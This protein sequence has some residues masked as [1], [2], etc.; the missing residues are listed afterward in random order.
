MYMKRQLVLKNIKKQVLEFKKVAL[1]K[2]GK[3][4]IKANKK[5]RGSSL[6]YIILFLVFFSGFIANN[7]YK[8]AIGPMDTNGSDINI[9]IPAGS[10]TDKIANILY[11]NELI[12]NKIIFKFHVLS[13][14]ANG[15]LKAGKFDL[16][17]NMALDDVINSLTVSG[18]AT[19]TVR[20]TIPEGYELN[21]IAEKLANENIVNKDRFLELTKDKANFQEKYEFLKLLEDGQSLEGFLFPSTYEIYND[22][23]EEV[24]IEKM[25]SQFEKIYKSKIEAKMSEL[26]LDLNEIVTLASMVEREAV[27][28]KERSIMAGVLYNRLEIDMPLQIDATVQYALGERKERLLFKDLEIESPYNTYLYK[29]L[30]PGPISSP[31]ENSIIATVNPSDVDYFFYVLK[32][33]NSGEHTFTKTFN[34]HIEAK[35][36]K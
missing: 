8:Q 11:D 28:D 20:F 13:L 17:T 5:K 2:G 19:N 6:K 21:Q 12:M 36:K 33:D 18:K 14:N 9:E 15:K 29:G 27:V 23:G 7:Y 32:G 31:G 25:L 22:S 34:E 4:M 16:N 10:S 3:K 24:V 1:F 35:P 30:P 26:D